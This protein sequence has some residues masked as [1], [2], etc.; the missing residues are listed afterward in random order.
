VLG[1]KHLP[2]ILKLGWLGNAPFSS[3]MFPV[4]PIQFIVGV[5]MI[6]PLKPPF[7]SPFRQPRTEQ[8]LQ[9]LWY[10]FDKNGDGSVSKE[11]PRRR[12]FGG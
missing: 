1:E 12:V 6:F 3:I 8:Q 7:V 10:S 9:E 2:S 5:S 4:K 11:D